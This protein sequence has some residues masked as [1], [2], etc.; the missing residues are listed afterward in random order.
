MTEATEFQSF[1]D[2]WPHYVR[3]HSDKTNRKL[4]FIGTTLAMACVGGAI[5]ARRRSLLLLAP[6]VGYGF[7]WV[8]HF[9]FEKNVPATFGHP[10]WSLRADFKMWKKILDGSMDAEVER[11]MRESAE[12]ARPTEGA[13]G[14][15]ADVTTN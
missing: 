13:N 5:L 3:A 4:H 2:F 7:A 1:E 6:V 11:V 8:G 15:P 12:A 14:A 9:G 10:A